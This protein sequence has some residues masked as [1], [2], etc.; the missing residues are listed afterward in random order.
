M[1][2]P[3]IIY[4]PLCHPSPGFSDG[5]CPFAGYCCSKWGYCGTTAEY[6]ED[7]SVA[8]APSPVDGS[9]AAPTYSIEAGQ[10]AKGDVGDD[11]CPDENHCCSEYGYCGSGEQYCY[12]TTINE[13]DCDGG[14]DEEIGTCGGRFS[15]IDFFSI[16]IFIIP[17]FDFMVRS[18]E[19][20]LGTEFAVMVYAV[21]ST[22]SAARVSCIAQV[23]PTT[24][25]KQVA[26]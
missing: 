9:P 5:I 2:A 13:G 26:R 1:L 6:C 19:E 15:S 17:S 4:H 3:L 12:T 8:P 24:C 21:R 10:C 11:F 23:K 7:D 16:S 22:A 20:E 18:Q 14:C 25:K